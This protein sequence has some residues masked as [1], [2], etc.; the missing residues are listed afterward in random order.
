[1]SNVEHAASGLILNVSAWDYGRWHWLIL[2][3][4]LA[5]G[6]CTRHD[7]PEGMSLSPDAGGIQ[8]SNTLDTSCHTSAVGEACFSCRRILLINESPHPLMAE[9]VPLLQRELARIR[10]VESV[11]YNPEGA[12]L[13]DGELAPDLVIRLELDAVDEQNKGPSRLLTATVTLSMTSD[14]LAGPGGYHDSFS[15]PVLTVEYVGTLKHRSRIIDDDSGADRYRLAAGNIAE[16]FAGSLKPA[17]AQWQAKHGAMPQLPAAFYGDYRPADDLAFL[18]EARAQR[19]GSFRG[20]LRHNETA[21]RFSD[22]RDASVVLG[23]IRQKLEAK[24]WKQ[25]SGQDA[26]NGFAFLWLEKDSRLIHA[27]RRQSNG[28]APRAVIQQP[29]GAAYGVHYLGRYSPQ[30]REAALVQLI[31]AGA[32]VETLLAFGSLCNS[33][34]LRARLHAALEKHQPTSARACLHLASHYR[35][36]RKDDEKARQCLQRAVILSRI[37]E[38]GPS[39]LYCQIRELATSLGDEKLADSPLTEALMRDLGIVELEADVP[40]ERTIR[41]GDVVLLACRT[42]QGE[43]CTLCL[44]VVEATTPNAQ[45][46]YE[47]IG[48]IASEHGRTCGRGSSANQSGRWS[49]VYNVSL[50]GFFPHAQAEQLPEGRFHVTVKRVKG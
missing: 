30:E 13:P 11:L 16:Q 33:D 31:D 42:S 21:W 38:E 28:I 15:P 25:V 20:L 17:L 45:G 18:D 8:A 24:G 1:M 9:V 40:V 43:R 50:N 46:P 3:A 35:E 47:L 4:M 12:A 41:L 32:S 10:S 49:A 5:I 34:T 44:K 48:I 23:E 26:N 29:N 2:I 14:L 22:P 27:F 39:D 36:R 7:Q 6:G 19:L 37:A